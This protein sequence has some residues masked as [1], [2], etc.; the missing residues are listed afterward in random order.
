MHKTIEQSEQRGKLR[1]KER[2]KG[3]KEI[4]LKMIKLTGSLVCMLYLQIM[5]AKVEL[6]ADRNFHIAVNNKVGTIP[7]IQKITQIN[8]NIVESKFP[9][10]YLLEYHSGN[11]RLDMNSSSCFTHPVLCSNGFS[12]SLWLF[13][14]DTN[15][16]VVILAMET[17]E[18]SYN[19][20]S[21]TVYVVGN[22]YPNV[23][24]YF[25]EMEVKYF[26]EWQ[27]WNIEYNPSDREI[28]LRRNLFEEKVSIVRNKSP[29]ALYGNIISIGFQFTGKMDDIYFWSTRLSMADLIGVRDSVFPRVSKTITEWNCL[30]DKYDKAFFD[31]SIG[32]CET[33]GNGIVNMSTGFVASQFRGFVSFIDKNGGS[34]KLRLSRKKLQCIDGDK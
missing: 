29:K 32:T 24:E 3:R 33:V 26:D 20:V 21:K 10:Q 13:L 17:L 5:I 23:N 2:E 25:V 8:V 4:A 16:E 28:I 15:N 6:T 7:M 11:L 12:I 14:P 1:D 18:F 34:E 30:S 19:P 31:N 9:S 27:F 22:L